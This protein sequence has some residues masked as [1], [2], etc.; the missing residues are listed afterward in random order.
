[1]HSDS[2]SIPFLNGVYGTIVPCC[3]I[4]AVLG[5]DVLSWLD[6]TRSLDGTMMSGTPCWGEVLGLL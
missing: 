1:M 5:I 4:A 6:L 3:R 2:F